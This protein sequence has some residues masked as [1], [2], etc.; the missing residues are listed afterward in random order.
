MLKFKLLEAQTMSRDQL[1][2][3]AQG[4]DYLAR[5]FAY[6]FEGQ[7]L[8]QGLDALVQDL[9]RSGAATQQGTELH[10]A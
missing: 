4:T 8:A 7:S 5:L 3:W 9:V 6:Q 10:N 2:A 1:L